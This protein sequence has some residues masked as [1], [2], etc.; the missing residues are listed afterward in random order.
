[1]DS[2]LKLTPMHCVFNARNV[3]SIA[4]ERSYRYR[5]T[6]YCY[7]TGGTSESF[8]NLLGSILTGIPCTECLGPVRKYGGR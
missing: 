7:G 6:Q 8:N 5:T 1:M 2:T 4:G 3:F